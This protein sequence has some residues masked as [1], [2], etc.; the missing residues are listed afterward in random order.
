MNVLL[1]TDKLMTGGAEFYFCRLENH[2]KHPAIDVYTAAGIGDLY[3]QIADKQRFKEMKLKNH[4][5]NLSTILKIVQSHQIDVIH[6]N[7]LRMFMYAVL[8]QKRVKRKIKILY[9]K[10]NVTMLEKHFRFLFAKLLN[11]HAAKVIAVS[12]A[13]KKHLIQLGIHSSIVTT[14]HNGVDL[15]QFSFG[16]RK[17]SKVYK[18]GI[19]A[20]LSPEKNH[21]LFLNIANQLRDETGIMFYIAGEGPERERIED[22]IKEFKLEHHVK[23]VGEVKK[24]EEFIKEMDV[25]LLTSHREVFPMV[26]LEAMAVGTPIVSVDTGGIKEAIIS[27]ESGFLVRG[28]SVEDFCRNV[29][30]LRH[31][32]LLREKIIYGA[33]ERVQRS[34]SL[35]HMVQ[36]TV[37]EYLKAE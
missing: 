15:Q 34:F 17:R 36:Q 37:S 14:I 22:Q 8:I 4:F 10:H 19:L 24:P 13:E 16:S 23:M 21:Q 9:T 31:N 1:I 6:A 11:H 26:V 2:I 30:L 32:R 7:S 20:R 18:V 5:Y 3:Q 12:E 33:R 28:Y 35:D 29:K 25:L 27:S